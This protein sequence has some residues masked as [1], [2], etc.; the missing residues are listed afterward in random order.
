MVALSPTPI[1]RAAN[2]PWG[3]SGANMAGAA[4]S[5]EGLIL[6][7]SMAWMVHDHPI[8][9]HERRCPGDIGIPCIQKEPGATSGKMEEHPRPRRGEG[10]PSSIRAPGA[11]SWSVRGQL[12]PHGIGA[13]HHPRQPPGWNPG[14]HAL[15]RSS[16]PTSRG[17]GPVPSL[18]PTGAEGGPGVISAINVR[19][20]Q[21]GYRFGAASGNGDGGAR[22]ALGVGICT[23]PA[24]KSGGPV[25]RPCDGGVKGRGVWKFLL[26]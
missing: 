26:A 19:E 22:K 17:G 16:P 13:E 20:A 15:P 12:R 2:H 6:G 3:T 14:L 4:D 23:C 11:R 25:S 10:T 7:G 8:G 9:V 18:P 5:G 21:S 24:L 1:P